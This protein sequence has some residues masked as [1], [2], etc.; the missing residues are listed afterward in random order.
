MEGYKLT[1]RL[2]VLGL[3]VVLMI[4][5]M[6]GRLVG[7]QIMSEPPEYT[8]L[9]E[10]AYSHTVT[11]PAARG[12]ILDRYGRPLVTNRLMYIVTIDRSYL[13]T[14][15]VPWETIHSLIEK[16]R[17]L[18]LSY[19]DTLPV[20]TPPYRYTEMDSTVKGQMN[21]YFEKMQ[22]GGGV[23]SDAL[24]SWNPEISAE[25][26][27]TRLFVEYGMAE[28]DEETGRVTNL[29]GLSQEE[30][31][32]IAGVLY[33]V[34]M[35]YQAGL[36]DTNLNQK[37]FYV[38]SY[39]F[40]Q[41]V[42]IE[43]MAHI[44]ENR[45]HGVLVTTQ[46]VR[47]YQTEAAAHILG[48]V[49]KIF[50]ENADMYK[51]L[52]Y[53]MDELVGVD[54]AEKAFESWL[55][56]T[57]GKETIIT[58]ANGKTKQK[59]VV[60]PQA[61]NNVYLTLDIRLQTEVERILEAGV[62]KLNDTGSELKGKEAEAAA[63]VIL[64]VKT[65]EVLAAAN[66]PTYN[67]ATFN[68]D[69][70]S[71]ME[72]PLKPML[73]RA[74]SGTYAPGSTFKMVTASAALENNIVT[75]NTIIYDRGIY[76]YYKDAQPSCWV[77]PSNHG[78]E[79]VAGALRDSC[80]YYFF[81]TGRLAGIREIDRWAKLYGLGEL[82]GIEIDGEKKGLVA[83]PETSKMF[84]DLWTDGNTLSASIGQQNNQ[85]TPI[86]LANYI[87]CIANGGT[88]NKTHLLREVVSY[89]YGRS[90]YFAQTEKIHTLDMEP[91]NL[92]A[93]QRGMN[94]VTAEGTARSVFGNYPIQ[95]AGKTGSVQVGDRPNNGVFVL[96]APYED[97]Q[98]AVVL[99]VEKGGAGSIIA[100]LA[101]D[102]VDAWFRLQTDLTVDSD[103][104]SLKR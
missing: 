12:S 57:A 21:H 68:E 53:S 93:I 17:E 11:V 104:N 94:L 51:Q 5:V 65:S 70:A 39:V 86:Q 7:L 62:K 45:L 2:F 35:R 34:E 66:Y 18:N 31:R 98:I 36:A 42:P 69:Y 64:D 79:T 67:L 15:G 90:Y 9:K 102:I 91:Q 26:F 101:R 27:M 37:Y 63:A 25:E 96:Y 103:E 85:F 76:T 19:T 6:G 23:S 49:G 58:D 75:P 20:S 30:M 97:P 72:D 3:L 80:N 1:I 71:L 92:L 32:R 8:E 73:N 95:V 52:G 82:T 56:G 78:P 87:A 61:G 4:F 46:N 88:L 99:V 47:E 28:R 48:R 10:S 55:H 81:E 100:P 89:D 38:P 16:T 44:S 13:H 33:E 14:G 22:W 77:Y 24:A 60:S 29:T 41:D 40:A 84:N 54:G 59:T 74:I 43:L 83:G 50:E